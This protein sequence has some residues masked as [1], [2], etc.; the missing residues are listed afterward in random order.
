MRS[1][2]DNVIVK[3]TLEFALILLIIQ[4]YWKNIESM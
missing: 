4:N 2:K 3:L 1:D